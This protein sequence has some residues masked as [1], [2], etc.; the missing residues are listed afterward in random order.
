MP[1]VFL[2]ERTPLSPDLFTTQEAIDEFGMPDADPK[3]CKVYPQLVLVESP[4][5]LRLYARDGVANVRGMRVH[6]KVAKYAEAAFSMIWQNYGQDRII[7]LGLDV[8][9]GSYNVRLKRGSKTLSKH[10]FGIA[11]DWLHTENGLKTP[12]KN[13][14]FSKPEYKD[15][16]DIWQECGFLNL[17][18][19]P[20]F[21]RD[22]MHFEF[23]KTGKGD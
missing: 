22:A 21:G 4:Y 19:L 15:F 3:V 8:F 11:H 1:N 17:G 7:R 12:F 5:R 14:T 16:L 20:T 2:L 18:R 9:S 10:S 6:S 23:M 13:A